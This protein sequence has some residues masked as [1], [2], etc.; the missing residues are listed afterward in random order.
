MGCVLSIGFP[1]APVGDGVAGGAEAVLAALDA[2]LVARGHE[3]V[4]VAARGSCVA[5]RLVAIPETP[6]QIDEER[7][8]AA[9]EA[10]RTA[11]E[12]VL[13][14]RWIDVVHM[15]G[16]EAARYAPR[17]RRPVVV[18]HHLPLAW[19]GVRIDG[20]IDVAVS[21]AQAR[22]AASQGFDVRLIPNGVRIPPAGDGARS[23][24]VW[25]GRICPE[26][27]PHVAAQAAKAVDAPLRA[28]GAVFGY[29]AHVRYARGPFANALDAQRI[30]I[31]PVG[32]R[33]RTQLLEGAEALVITS[34][35]PETSSLVAMEAAAAGAPVIALAAG[36]VGEIVV[37]G[38]SGFVASDYDVLVDALA[39]RREIDPQ[40]CKA[41][42]QARFDQ[43]RMIDAYLRLYDEIS[44]GAF[45]DANRSAV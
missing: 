37:D 9:Y 22:D 32:A 35:A 29:D 26:K 28:A 44:G 6:V 7:R 10:A 1:L 31:G 3:S 25:I 13:A 36:A 38:V 39:R 8:V 23:G 41:V 42:A 18:T 4:V 15:H 5:G 19:D 43:E 2:G 33:R 40:V 45:A 11:A 20:A 17:T 21:H 14:R 34:A 12:N 16:F 27:Q 24:L 30:W